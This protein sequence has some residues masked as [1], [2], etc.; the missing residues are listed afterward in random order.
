M[1]G[2]G[3]IEFD[4]LR[5]GG[6]KVASPIAQNFEAIRT[7]ERAE[8]PTQRYSRVR[9]MKVDVIC[10]CDLFHDANKCEIS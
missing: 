9:V 5:L 6:K 3:L 10:F 7:A 8:S 1:R 4:I 2:G